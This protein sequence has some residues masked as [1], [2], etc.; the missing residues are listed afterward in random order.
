MKLTGPEWDRY[1]TLKRGLS[2]QSEHC[3]AVHQQ[4]YMHQLQDPA[5]IRQ[6]VADARF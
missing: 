5:R 4:D 2:S 1:K 6:P 3:V